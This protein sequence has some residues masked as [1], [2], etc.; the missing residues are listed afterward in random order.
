MKRKILAIAAHPD[1]ETLGCGATLLKHRASG[2]ELTWVIVTRAYVPKWSS[3]LISKKAEEVRKA[4]KAYGIKKYFHLSFPAARLDRVPQSELMDELK[5]VITNIRPDTIY[6]VNGADVHSDH[7]AVFRA[8]MSVLKPFYML[9]MGVR[10]VLCYETM[11]STEA[12]AMALEKTKA[13]DP[14]V[15]ND[16]SPYLLKKLKILAMYRTET[17]PNP[18]PRGAE[19]VKALA[20]LRGATV[21]VKYAEAFVLIRELL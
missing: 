10:R 18:M 4:A 7:Q 17:Q 19:A 21:G 13:F 12:A 20:R 16:V 5:K 3:D 11:S 2:D 1:D 6:L 14:T 8:A 9:K 15:F